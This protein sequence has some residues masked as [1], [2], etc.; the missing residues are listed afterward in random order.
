MN[1]NG[2][3]T[4]PVNFKADV[5]TVLGTSNTTESALCT[6]ANINM[7]AK[8]KPVV[9]NSVAPDRNSEWWKSTDGNCGI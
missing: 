8:Y 5:A 3:I 1:S 9:L 7:W 2:K 4:A 6:N